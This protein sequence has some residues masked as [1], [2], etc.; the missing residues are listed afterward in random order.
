MLR[1]R[2]KNGKFLL[3]NNFIKFHQKIVNSTIVT[4]QYYHTT[5]PTYLVILESEPSQTSCSYTTA[6]LWTE[7]TSF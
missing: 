1:F 3:I 5:L 7:E 4:A 6:A 2:I